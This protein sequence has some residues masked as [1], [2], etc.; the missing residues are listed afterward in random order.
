[1]RN[2]STIR[3]E[4]YQYTFGDPR[5]LALLREEIPKLYSEWRL[6]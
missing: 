5:P 6:E 3:K 2:F 4:V 1:V